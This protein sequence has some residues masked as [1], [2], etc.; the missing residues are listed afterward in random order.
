MNAPKES[1]P[2]EDKNTAKVIR[3][4]QSSRYPKQLSKDSTHQPTYR[5]KTARTKIKTSS[6]S[7][8]C[9]LR[10]QNERELL[11]AKSLSESAIT[12]LR[13]RQGAAVGEGNLPLYPYVNRRKKRIHQNSSVSCDGRI[14]S[15]MSLS[16]RIFLNNIDSETKY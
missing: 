14:V 13:S 3:G 15:Y 1:T 5:T 9:V 10:R 8:C 2:S 11:P 12:D 6:R 4:Q 7:I 16:F